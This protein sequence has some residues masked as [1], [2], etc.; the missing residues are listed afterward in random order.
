MTGI[1]RFMRAVPAAIVVLGAAVLLAGCKGSTGSPAPGTDVTKSSSASKPSPGR[2]KA[3]PSTVDSAWASYGVRSVAM[4][5]LVNTSTMPTA[6]PL[7]S[8][9]VEREL[10][11]EARHIYLGWD[12]TRGAAS[13]RGAGEEYGRLM[14]SWQKGRTLSAEQLASFGQKL[15]VQAV[16]VG[17]IARW[18][19]KKL[20]F[21]QEGN[22]TT[23]VSISLA[24]FATRDGKQIWSS[25]DTRNEKSIYYSP[26]DQNVKYDAT[27]RAQSNTSS[28]AP[29]PPPIEEVA[30]KVVVA[31][32]AA[33]PQ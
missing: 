10:R 8:G 23:D 15:G 14:A 13:A 19:T 16:L 17:E 27:G 26:G 28:L 11:R 2:T 12:E 24:L 33:V 29:D 21:D 9:M 30:R 22:S 1:G 6:G 3:A 5:S 7:V 32:T 25:K 18:E 20:T 31:V 4:L